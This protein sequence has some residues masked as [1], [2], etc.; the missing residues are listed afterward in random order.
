[1]NKLKL[2]YY[3]CLIKKLCESTFIL[4]TLIHEVNFHYFLVILFQN[5]HIKLKSPPSPFK[6]YYIEEKNNVEDG[7]DMGEIYYLGDLL[8]IFI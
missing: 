2:I 4:V 1:M 5:N 8:N 3:L 7:G 6:D